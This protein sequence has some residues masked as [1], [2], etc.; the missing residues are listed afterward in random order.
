VRLVLVSA[1]ERRVNRRHVVHANCRA[2]DRTPVFK[3]EWGS[4]AMRNYYQTK[5][6]GLKKI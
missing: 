5:K 3:K 6:N 1:V 4:F 2:S